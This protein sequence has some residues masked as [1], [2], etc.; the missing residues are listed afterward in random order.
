MGLEPSSWPMGTL[1]VSRLSLGLG[2]A[3]GL[4]AFLITRLV[5]T[6]A[7]PERHGSRS[8]VTNDRPSS[9]P[10]VP[11]LPDVQPIHREASSGS[12][13]GTSSS[14]NERESVLETA[15]INALRNHV[16]DET[17]RDAQR[18]GV[19]V[20]DCLNGI[21]LGVDQRIRISIHASSKP[22]EAEVGRWRFVEVVDGQALPPTFAACLER[23]LGGGF[24]IS[25]GP[26]EPFPTYEGEL[27]TIYRLDRTA[28]NP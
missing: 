27:S 28:S 13:S 14:G 4:A 19:S 26:G 6:D 16:L 11:V 9:K 12:S 15:A 10:R 5:L 18:R 17:G 25:A 20:L 3:A 23:V 24:R 7:G 8:H 22:D 1:T 2:V 21:E